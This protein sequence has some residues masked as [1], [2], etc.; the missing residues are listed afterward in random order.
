M[1]KYIDK[2][3]ELLE[4]NIDADK[5]A[6]IKWAISNLENSQGSA[7]KGSNIDALKAIA[8]DEN[9]KEYAQAL[10]WAIYSLENFFI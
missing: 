7:A 9:Y 2:L 8:E 3:N 1:D 4:K 5:A 6:A 10:N